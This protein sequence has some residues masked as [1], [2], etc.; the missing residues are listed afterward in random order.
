MDRR[1]L[2]LTLSTSNEEK[3]KMR[4]IQINTYRSVRLETRQISSAVYKNEELFKRGPF[5]LVLL[6]NVKLFYRK[7]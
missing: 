5:L 6:R 4:F 7:T 3:K 2:S 1:F